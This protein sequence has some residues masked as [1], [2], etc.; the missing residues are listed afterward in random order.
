VEPNEAVAKVRDMIAAQPSLADAFKAAWGR[1]CDKI[2][3]RALAKRPKPRVFEVHHET[4]A[5]R[6]A[7]RWPKPSRWRA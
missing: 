3:A 5:A 4:E 7:L 6:V 1:V 2:Q